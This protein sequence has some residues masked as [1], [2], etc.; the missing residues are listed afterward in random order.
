MRGA[1]ATGLLAAFLLRPA[2]A[3]DET[4]AD[5]SRK[6]GALIQQGQT[7]AAITELKRIVGE[8]PR[9]FPAYSLMGGAY[10]QLGKLQDAQ[11]Y[12]QKAVELAPRSLEA[13][14]NLGVNYLALKKP[15]ETARQFETV[16]MADPATVTAWVN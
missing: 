5:L 13:R 9:Y 14:N 6:A 1:L 2:C 7:Q 10:S 3:E 16:I 8:W 4:A 12:F 11:P 15:A